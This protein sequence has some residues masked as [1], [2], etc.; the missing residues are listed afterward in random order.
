MRNDRDP[1]SKREKFI[2]KTGKYGLLRNIEPATSSF[3]HCV[4]SRIQTL[5]CESSA[6][7]LAV[8][9]RGLRLLFLSLALGIS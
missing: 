7:M 2:T 3:P 5:P 8:L 1:A 4:S 6:V 9:G